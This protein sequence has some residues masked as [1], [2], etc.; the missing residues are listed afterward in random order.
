MSWHYFQNEQSHGPIR[1]KDIIKLMVQGVIN[2]ETYFWCEGMA[3]WKKYSE[4]FPNDFRPSPQGAT[5]ILNH[6][7]QFGI[8]NLKGDVA[9]QIITTDTAALEPIL[10]RAIQSTE[11]VPKCD[12]LFLYCDLDLNAG[13]LNSKDGLFEIIRNSG[14]V[15]AVLAS[16]NRGESFVALGKL[17]RGKNDDSTNFMMTNNRAG[18][19]FPSF[20]AKLFTD[21]L[22]RGVSFGEAFVK[23]APQGP[24]EIQPD[25][26]PGML[27]L[28]NGAV[29]FI[30]K[31]RALRK[32][33]ESAAAFSKK[34]DAAIQP[35][36]QSLVEIVWEICREEDGSVL[37]VEV[38]SAMA[39]I[40]GERCIVAADEIDVRGDSYFPKQAAGLPGQRVFSDVAN[41][42]LV[43]NKAELTPESAFGTIRDRLV[44]G[45]Y[46][47]QFSQTENVM[48]EF[49]KRIGNPEDWGKV[50]LSLPAEF[51][52]K[53][54]PLRVAFDARA[55]VEDALKKITENQRECL[56]ISAIALAA[57]LVNFKEQIDRNAALRLALETV[58]GMA[59]T[60]PMKNEAIETVS[61]EILEAQRQPIKIGHG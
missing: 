40:V 12:V 8:F 18:P 45:G 32:L 54:L 44:A 49:A 51:N 11:A 13:V 42:L 20:F 2:P 1:E 46:E 55:Q 15:I 5:T 56:R 39:A 43:G 19:I 53:R 29:Y 59:K 33:Q 37:P 58:N 14:A 27:G 30:N 10:G 7:V 24:P 61:S 41:E 47:C 38:I 36:V 57:V 21:M 16:E 6:I 34:D 60:L 28:I 26:I 4:L 52:P 50:P 3:D 31:S 17:N 25:E 48:G 35:A 9:Q 23:L 22:Q